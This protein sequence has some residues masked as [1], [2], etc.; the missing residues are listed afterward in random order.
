MMQEVSL[1]AGYV[2]LGDVVVEGEVHVP[3][4]VAIFLDD[5]PV[6]KEDSQ[7]RVMPPVAFNLVFRDRRENSDPVSIWQPIP[8]VPPDTE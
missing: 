1:D 2:R 7:A 5:G 8:P 6:T 4:R 3:E